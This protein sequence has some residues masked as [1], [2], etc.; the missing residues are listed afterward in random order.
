[1]RVVDPQKDVINVI[2]AVRIKNNG[3]WMRILRIALD[4]DPERTRQVLR[5]VRENDLLISRLT[6]EL[7]NEDSQ[8][9]NLP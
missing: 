1:M 5:D 3:L 4:S 2:E 7:I 8:A 9:D 6:G